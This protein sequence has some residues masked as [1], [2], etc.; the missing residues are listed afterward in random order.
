M[1]LTES[2]RRKKNTLPAW[3]AAISDDLKLFPKLFTVKE[4]QEKHLLH[5]LVDSPFLKSLCGRNSNISTVFM[6]WPSLRSPP[7]LG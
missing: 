3:L 4:S 2:M 5:G 1:K 6:V 7:N